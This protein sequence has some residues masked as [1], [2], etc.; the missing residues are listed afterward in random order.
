M[1][2]N[3]RSRGKEREK[4]KNETVRSLDFKRQQIYSS[5]TPYVSYLSSTEL[6]LDR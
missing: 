1:N 2:G 4:K 6:R 5:P 3:H